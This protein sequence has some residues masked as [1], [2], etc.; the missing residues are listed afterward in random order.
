M[1]KSEALKYVRKNIL[2]MTRDAISN[3]SG[4]N[5]RSIIS[6]ED[7]NEIR[8]RYPQ[9]QYIVFL[10]QKINIQ[11]EFWDKDEFS[12]EDFANIDVSEDAQISIVERIK[13]KLLSMSKS[14]AKVI[15]FL[16]NSKIEEWKVF[17]Q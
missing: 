2:K 14:E 6:W 16:V 9:K 7:N 5:A 10:S 15:E 8:G 4:F 3:I 13:E 1:T 17:K 11:V 12:E